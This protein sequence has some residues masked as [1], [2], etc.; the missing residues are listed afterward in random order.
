MSGILVGMDG[1]QGPQ[2]A[3]ASALEGGKLRGCEVRACYVLDPRYVE[4]EWASLMP[5]RFL[6]SQGM[7][8][9]DCHERCRECV[10]SIPLLLVGMVLQPTMA[11]TGQAIALRRAARC[12]G[13]GAFDPFVFHRR[14]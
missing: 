4:P 5:H 1:S 2:K 8:W 12:I 10:A 3:L 14:I 7:G 9:P 13:L 11:F 6:S